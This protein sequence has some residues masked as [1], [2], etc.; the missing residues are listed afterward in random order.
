[1]IKL[2]TIYA[3][4]IIYLLIQ[5]LPDHEHHDV[6]WFEPYVYFEPTDLNSD[7]MEQEATKAKG[8]FIQALWTQY[9][10]PKLYSLIYNAWRQ[11]G[12]QNLTT[13][14]QLAQ[15]VLDGCF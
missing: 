5:V 1:M 2:E 7:Y 4:N 10:I 11:Y 6:P 8:A 3:M 14:T 12:A 15:A 9:S 13:W